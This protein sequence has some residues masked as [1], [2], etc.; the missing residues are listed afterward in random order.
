MVER[1]GGLH[2]APEPIFHP[3][4]AERLARR[5]LYLHLPILTRVVREVDGGC[6]LVPGRQ[7]RLDAKLAR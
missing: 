4:V 2:G 3:Y 1:R 6:G 7:Q 5:A